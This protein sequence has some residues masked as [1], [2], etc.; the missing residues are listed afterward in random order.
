MR[1]TL[2]LAS[3]WLVL[4]C[5]SGRAD[6]PP[7]PPS[8]DPATRGTA[9]PAAAPA[10]STPVPPS[11][12]DAVAKAVATKA[13]ADGAAQDPASA[14]TGDETA[15]TPANPPLGW[16]AGQPLHAEELL[17]EWGDVSAREM[18]LVLDKLVAARLALAE[19]A[20]LGIRLAP[21][22]VEQRYEEQKDKLEGELARSDPPRT[23][24]D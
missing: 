11:A 4:G 8:F 7:A 17:V 15:E 22:A 10:P 21:E 14:A 23:L 12:A 18:W 20:R 24:E 9:P 13:A 6:R 1:L 3:A 16:I 19:A 2:A 5:A